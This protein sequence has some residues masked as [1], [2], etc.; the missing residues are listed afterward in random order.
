MPLRSWSVGAAEE[1][2]LFALKLSEDLHDAI[3]VRNAPVSI[4]LPDGFTPS[5]LLKS[6]NSSDAPVYLQVGEERIPVGRMAESPL[7]RVMRLGSSGTANVVGEIAEKWI[8]RQ[9]LAPAHH[10]AV[11]Q[12]S[13]E[14]ERDRRSR[15]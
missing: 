10:S 5:D 8:P 6:S 12:A 13:Q 15:K 2:R 4:V 14:A 9:E 7:V 1:Q 11:R 3:F